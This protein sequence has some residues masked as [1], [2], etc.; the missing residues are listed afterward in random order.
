MK[1]IEITLAGIPLRIGLF[2]PENA[3]GFGSY[4]T[5]DNCSGHEISVDL[6]EPRRYPVICPDGVLTPDSEIYLLMPHVSRTLLK[7]GRVLFHGAAFR[8][9]GRAWI[10]T[11]PS[12]TGKTTQLRNW[13]RLW[14]DELELI[15]GDKVVLA[16]EKDGSFWLLPSPWTGKEGD[17]GSVSAPLGGIVLLRQAKENTVTILSPGE[18][19]LRM[20]DQLLIT[21][22]TEEE[23]VEAAALLDSMLR[24]VPVWRLDNLGDLDSA[25]L[26]RRKLEEDVP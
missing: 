21:A 24:V 20:F 15:G 3:K 18:A 19:V 10:F 12:G 17:R 9:R 22:E 7:Y 25:Y 26:M 16:Q 14:P 13:Q 23:I 2:F 11:A 4:I 6:D 1:E 5:Q 8:W